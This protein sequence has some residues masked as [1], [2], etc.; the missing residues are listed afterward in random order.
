MKLWFKIIWWITIVSNLSANLVLIVG[1]S[2]N[3]QRKIDLDSRLT[4]LVIGLPSLILIIMSIV[5][6]LTK[7]ASN[8]KLTSYIPGVIIIIL[9]IL[10]IPP[11]IKEIKNQ[12]E[13]WIYQQVYSDPI[14]TTEDGKYDYCLEIVNLRGRSERLYV[15]N[16]TTQEKT[17]L[18]ISLE[19]SSERSLTYGTGNWSWA[20]LKSINQNDEYQLITT[21]K[22]D[23]PIQI[24][25]INMKEKNVKKQN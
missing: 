11:N 10:L 15:K 21:E 9:L 18:P 16:N 13:G 12:T 20:H 17:Y 25:N 19:Y 7:K 2:A 24:F 1:A 5:G 3:F 14:K 23:A 8:T 22:L 6:L 4:L